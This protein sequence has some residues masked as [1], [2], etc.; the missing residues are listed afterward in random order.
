MFDEINTWI[1]K[2]KRLDL[3]L[4]IGTRA[5]VFP[6]ARFVARAREK[7][8]RI[9]VIDLDEGGEGVGMGECGGVPLREG[10]DWRFV[11][12]AAEVLKVLFQGVLEN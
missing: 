3:M 10:K 4:V 5:E 8:A 7:G 11:G 1:D 6:A 2:E 12:D 9:A